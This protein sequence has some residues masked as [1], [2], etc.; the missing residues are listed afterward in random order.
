LP[1]CLK[2]LSYDY[3]ASSMLFDRPASVMTAS[4]AKCKSEI[5][6]NSKFQATGGNFIFPR[7]NKLDLH[8]LEFLWC[9]F[10]EFRHF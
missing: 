3:L 10:E 1:S 8:E 2:N 6:E 9:A 5:Q 7:E 4:K